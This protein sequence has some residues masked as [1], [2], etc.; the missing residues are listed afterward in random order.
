MNAD[1]RE[2][3]FLAHYT[4]NGVKYEKD[5]IHGKFHRWADDPIYEDEKYFPRTVALVEDQN[6]KVYKVLADYLTF[7]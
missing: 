1:L 3:T 7:I 4:A 2:A 6:G 5:P